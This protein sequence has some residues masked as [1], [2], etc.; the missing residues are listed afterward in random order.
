M[1]LLLGKTKWNHMYIM[2]LPH[3]NLLITRKNDATFQDRQRS[4][5]AWGREWS[6]PKRHIPF[7]IFLYFVC[8]PYRNMN[9]HSLSWHEGR[10][11]VRSYLS[12]R[13][14]LQYKANTGFTGEVQP[15]LLRWFCTPVNH[16]QQTAGWSYRAGSGLG[17]IET[18]KSGSTHMPGAAPGSAFSGSQSPAAVIVQAMMMSLPDMCKSSALSNLCS[19]LRLRSLLYRGRQAGK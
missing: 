19:E 8:V 4:L 16:F 3:E 11:K 9:H 15:K 1:E 12:N 13:E 2:N 17:K 5:S 18:M 7:V 10:D 6:A 14:R